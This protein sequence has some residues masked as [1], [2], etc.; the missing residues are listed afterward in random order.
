MLLS[1]PN[2]IAKQVKTVNTY[3]LIDDK[4]IEFR[5]FYAWTEFGKFGNTFRKGFNFLSFVRDESISKVI[6]T[7]TNHSR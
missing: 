3:T 4:Q 6:S 1:H 5:K 2:N 7:Q